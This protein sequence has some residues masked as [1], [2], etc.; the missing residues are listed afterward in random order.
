MLRLICIPLLFMS[1][2]LWA[3]LRPAKYLALAREQIA[4]ENYDAAIDHL[5]FC[6]KADP[7]NVEAF[8]LRGAS[9]YNL[10]DFAGAIADFGNCIGLYPLAAAPFQN[11]GVARSKTGDHEGAIADFDR[12][13]ALEP[14]N[15]SL[16]MSKAYSLMQ[17]AQ[18]PAAI[19]V[20]TRAI[21]LNPKVEEAWLM[22][23]MA[24][25][26]L[27]ELDASLADLN[28]ALR[29][30]PHHTEALLRRSLVHSEREDSGAALADCRRALALDSAS[31]LAWFVLG[32]LYGQQERYALAADAYARVTALNPRNALAHYN[33]GVANMQADAL[34]EAALDFQRVT[35]INPEN[36]LGHFN[37]ALI[38]HR[39]KDYPKALA[40]YDAV[41]ELYPDMEDAWFNRAL[42]KQE[43]GDEKGARSDYANGSMVR[44]E[45]GN[46]PE[47]FDRSMVR[48]ELVDL[49]AD[50]YAPSLRS[51]LRRDH[52]ALFPFIELRASAYRRSG[53]A[54]K[55]YNPA[56]DHRNRQHGFSPFF[57]LT[58]YYDE[59]APDSAQQT[60]PPGTDA[61][62]AGIYR[63]CSYR[64]NFEFDRSLALYDSLLKQYPGEFLLW[65]G[66]AGTMYYLLDLLLKLEQPDHA[67][68]RGTLMTPSLK[69]AQTD[70]LRLNEMEYLYSK[71]I[72]LRPDFAPAYFNRGLVRA[73]LEDF[74]AAID[75]FLQAHT[76]Q[77]NLSE[78][79]FNAAILAKYLDDPRA[80][81]YLMRAVINGVP[82]A[83]ELRKT[84]CE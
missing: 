58:N 72:A 46:Q 12:A 79:V 57:Y 4:L 60:L 47:G 35:D 39:R 77:N 34:R 54:L 82:Q 64:S 37:L 55:F 70:A 80:C 71:S 2:S 65:F 25:L 3:Q 48:D 84:W 69:S 73:E 11:R 50:F 44:A 16:Y 75:D 43:M 74:E 7:T 5:N 42:V 31:T 21:A 30:K 49:Q 23:G 66:K 1:I 68:P 18:T 27:G 32:S 81:D 26:D 19:E 62:T 14:E 45:R 59:T 63:A 83:K 6:I 51:R 8:Y 61:A 52:I 56:I 53:S 24:R 17:I 67:H 15:Y 76:L 10:G 33:R 28:E 13:L 9:R 36:V 38:Y 41:L 29:L 20:C 78:A 40:A 22:R